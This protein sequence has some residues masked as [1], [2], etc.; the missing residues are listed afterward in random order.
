MDQTRDKLGRTFFWRRIHSLTGLWIVLFL[1]EHIITNSQAALLV[2][3]SGM[4][5]I[6]A[7]NFIKDLPYLPAVEIGLI[8]TPIA[9]HAVWGIK[10]AL[11]A[12]SNSSVTNGTKPSLPE[13]G[14]NRS[15]TF[16]RI[17]SWIL[18]VGI[19][20]HVGY[21]RFYLYP[22]EVEEGI[23]SSYF[24]RVSKDPGLYPVAERLGVL[25]FDQQRIDEVVQAQGPQVVGDNL[26]EEQRI[27]YQKEWVAALQK[28]KLKS[29]QVIAVASDFGTAILLN[30][31]NAFKSPYEG[32]L[33]TIFVL[34]AAFHAFNGLWTFMIT[35]GVVLKMRSQRRAVNVCIGLMVLIGLLGLAS[36]WGTYWVNLK[37]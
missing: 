26:V 6:R 19:I 28:R 3:D 2:G 27:E 4:G 31:R 15:Y 22:V 29:N 34:A 36:I 8:G 32:V 1:I 9:L 23:H 24:V 14:R 37:Q 20:A 35:W 17:S 18:L 25:I 30:V 16:Q 7:V 11:T 21:M 5:F 13:Y 33:Y 10:Y 12:K